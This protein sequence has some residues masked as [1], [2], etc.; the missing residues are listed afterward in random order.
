M[1]KLLA[2]S[3]LSLVIL[4]A[5]GTKKMS[6]DEVIQKAETFIN[7]TLMVDGS[8]VTV[9]NVTTEFGLYK[10]SVNLAVGN[11][12]ESYMSKDG[13]KFFP[14]AIDI[15]IADEEVASSQSQSVD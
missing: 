11:S 13:L 3:L 4:T 12:V 6:E 15:E 1:N 10:F 5:C 14:Q 2:L 7:E 8:T 9:D